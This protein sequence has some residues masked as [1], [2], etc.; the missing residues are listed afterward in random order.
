VHKQQ[1][2]LLLN[3]KPS[4]RLKQAVIVSHILAITAS[5][6]N[7][8]P[9]AI[10]GA[11]LA[12]CAMHCYFNLKGLQNVS[13]KI[14]HSDVSGWEIA[15]IGEDFQSVQI[16]TTTVISSFL[17]LIHYQ[18]QS[19]LGVTTKRMRTLLVINDALDQKDYRSLVVRLKTTAVMSK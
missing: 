7:A 8:L 13:V 18:V 1:T 16:L 4:T 6:S 10:Q 2:P 14:K 11:L 17:V 15:D 9:I 5:I 19:T 3:P 12:A